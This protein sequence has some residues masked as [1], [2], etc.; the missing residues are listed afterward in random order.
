MTGQLGQSAAFGFCAALVLLGSELSAAQPKQSHAALVVYDDR[1]GLLL[2][3]VRQV[4][5]LRQN[6]KPVEIR[7]D[8][9]F[10]TCTLLLGARDVCVVATTVFGF[11][12]P[13]Y[14]GRPLDPNLFEHASQVIAQH[15]P[16]DIRDWY[17]SEARFTIDGLHTRSG[18][19][20]IDLGVPEC[21]RT[22]DA[23][24]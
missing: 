24:T 16:R 7:G 9:C 2:D 3:R 12:G 1:G 4:R 18:Q 5:S 8:I 19:D 20:L 15:Y 23:G 14:S 21:T 10:S 6:A 11:H 13:S 17:L 22:A